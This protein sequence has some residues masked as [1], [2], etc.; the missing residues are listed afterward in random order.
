MMT[1]RKPV[2]KEQSALN[3]HPLFET[4]VNLQSSPAIRIMDRYHERVAFALLN[5]DAI[6]R[7]KVNEEAVDQLEE[8]IEQLLL[9]VNTDI[10][11]AIERNNVLMN[12]NQITLVPEYTNPRSFDVR[13]RSP[14]FLSYIQIVTNLDTLM[15]QLDSLW[16]NRVVSNKKRSEET[17]QWQR[18]LAKLS[19]RIIHFERQVRLTEQK[20]TKQEESVASQQTEEEQ[21]ETESLTTEKEKEV[22]QSTEEVDEEESSKIA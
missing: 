14:Q 7:Y 13:V 10:N 1:Q 18:R 4:V 9:P 6:L 2:A 15:I 22:E 16:F 5:A 12:E 20:N 17:Y 3:S 8:T 11:N 21:V 19:N